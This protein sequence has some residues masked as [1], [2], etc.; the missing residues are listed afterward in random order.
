[1]NTRS[2][3]ACFILALFSTSPAFAQETPKPAKPAAPAAPEQMAPKAAPASEPKGKPVDQSQAAA[4]LKD[5]PRHGEWVDVPLAE[6]SAG[7]AAAG[8]ASVGAPIK[9]WIVY[10]ERP[11]KAPVVIVIHEIFGMSEWVRATTDQLAADGFIAI[12]PDLL[13]GKGPSGGATDSMKSS[14][15]GEAIR[16]LTPE[17]VTSRLNA[18]REFALKLPSAAQK[19]GC[20]GFCWGGSQSFRYASAQPAGGAGGGLAA[21][22][23]CYGTAPMKDSK[24]DNDTLSKI[25]CPV[26]GLYGGNDA[27]V[28]TTVAPTEEAM[29]A[30][31]KP[32]EQETYEGA[33][34]G[35]VR[36]QSSPANTDAAK[37]AW[38]RTIA[39]LKKNLE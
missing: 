9:T 17:E 7:G 11:D 36:Q 16:K 35:F 14:D 30:L 18:V 25:K 32:F 24:P 19:V 22:V 39:F 23:V 37:K 29:R 13:S 31:K 5:S 1:M 21:A 3:I 20:I 2:T 4:A 26:L 38:A 27:R 6:K 34:H 33:G 8:A 28:T 15:V 12:A 10:P